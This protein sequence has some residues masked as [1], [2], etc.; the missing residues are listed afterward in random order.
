M[1]NRSRTSKR[2]PRKI[3]RV[4]KCFF[5]RTKC[6]KSMGYGVCI[7]FVYSRRR[8]NP[9]ICLR[10]LF[11]IDDSRVDAN[12]KTT[13]PRPEIRICPPLPPKDCNEQQTLVTL[14]TTV[15][16]DT[17]NLVDEKITIPFNPSGTDTTLSFISPDTSEYRKVTSH[18]DVYNTVI[19]AVFAVEMPSQ[20][21]AGHETW[22]ATMT[23][24]RQMFHGTKSYCDPQQLLTKGLLCHNISCGLCGIIKEGNKLARSRSGGESCKKKDINLRASIYLNMRVC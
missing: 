9:F 23:K 6:G 17:G 8:H 24:G 22:S 16:T 18:F 2:F 7:K 21:K 4:I 10:M 3:T 14:E 15:T 19:T 11:F 13:T 1:A 12:N 20:I 5:F